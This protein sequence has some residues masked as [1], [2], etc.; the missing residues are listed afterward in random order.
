VAEALSE[1]GIAGL[2]DELRPGRPRSI[3]D[4]QVEEGLF[5]NNAYKRPKEEGLYEDESTDVGDK[6]CP[7]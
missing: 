1:Q 3:A 6:E 2:Y 7:V 5:R 4:E